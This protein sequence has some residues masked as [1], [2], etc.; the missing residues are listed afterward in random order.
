MNSDP[1]SLKIANGA[2]DTAQ[3]VNYYVFEKNKTVLLY[4]IPLGKNGLFLWDYSVSRYRSM[5]DFVFKE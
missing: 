3:S 5:V 4:E 2:R 1:S